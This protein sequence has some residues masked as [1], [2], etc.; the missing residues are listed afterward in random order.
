MSENSLNP[1]SIAGQL[2]PAATN[3][4][5]P[6]GRTAQL[7]VVN[8]TGFDMTYLKSDIAHGKVQVPKGEATKNTTDAFPTKLYAEKHNTSSDPDSPTNKEDVDIE[9]NN[10]FIVTNDDGALIGAFGSV[11][12]QFNV[13]TGGEKPE[14]LGEV[15]VTIYWNHPYGSSTSSYNVKFSTNDESL[16]KYLGSYA[17]SPSQPTGHDQ[18]IEISILYN[19]MK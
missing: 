14:I 12:Y 1:I 3:F 8:F 11:D 15:T 2:I 18:R 7:S 4:V 10:T 5:L 6:G 13:T 9:D 16:N 17:L 19:E